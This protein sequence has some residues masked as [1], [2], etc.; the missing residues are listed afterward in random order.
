MSA[1]K[2]FAVTVAVA[3]ALLPASGVLRADEFPARPI[4]V[5]VGFGPGAVADV[6]LRVL[7]NRMSQTLGQQ[8]VEQ[9]RLRRRQSQPMQETA[10]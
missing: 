9:P 2:P 7:T 10:V 1:S 5:V 3:L 4:R 6:I 8:L